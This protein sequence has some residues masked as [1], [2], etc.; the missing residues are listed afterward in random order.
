MKN[1]TLLQ[2]IIISAIINVS[3]IVSAI[4][5]AIYDCT[6]PY[7]AIFITLFMFAYHADIR[8]LVGLIIS[9]F[10]KWI[11]VDRDCFVISLKE[12]KRLDKLKI[13]KWKEHVLTL[14][15]NQF[16]MQGNMSK[17]RVET[18]L[19]NNINAEITHWVCFFVSFLAI[20]FGYL[21]SPE[22]IWIYIATSIVCSLLLD[23][24][25][26]LIQRYNRYRLLKIKN[27]IVEKV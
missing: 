13:K 11:N 1:K 12:Y 15:K 14:Y 19:K 8:L 9:I 5:F 20:L 3:F 23:L 24:P 26:I 18:I 25:F 16:V 10:K 22:E 2:V 27:K 4:L 7:V 6:Q 21:L 17:E